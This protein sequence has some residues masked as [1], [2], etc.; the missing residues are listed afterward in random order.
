MVEDLNTVEPPE[1]PGPDA[2]ADVRRL[3]FRQANASL[4]LEGMRP[5]SRDQALQELVARAELTPDQAVAEYFKRA[6][7]GTL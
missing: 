2:A 7:S 6:A 4:V 3:Q 5:D 1:Q